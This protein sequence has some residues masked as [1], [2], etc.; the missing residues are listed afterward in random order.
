MIGEIIDF[1]NALGVLY[2]WLLVGWTVPYVP[3]TL[4]F[5]TV[6]WNMWIDLWVGV[7]LVL[8]VMIVLSMLVGIGIYNL[9]EYGR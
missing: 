9:L 7:P 4:F 2:L 1:V 8:E 6:P 5:Y 3:A